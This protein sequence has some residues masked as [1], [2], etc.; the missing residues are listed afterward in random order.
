MKCLMGRKRAL[1][2]LMSLT[3]TFCTNAHSATRPFSKGETI[4][5]DIKKFGIHAGEATLVYNG[6][7]EVQGKKALLITFI[8]SG[9]KFFDEEQIYVDAQTFYPILIKRNLN[10][11]GKEETI[12]EFYDPQKGKV[13]IV[14]TAKG[15]TE[16]QTIERGGQ[17][18]NIYGFIYRLRQ[19]GRIQEGK[20]LDLHLP[21]QDLQFQFIERSTFLI[22]DQEFSTDT[23]RSI[24]KK[25]EVVF[26][27]SPNRIPLKIEGALGFGNMSMIFKNRLIGGH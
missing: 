9:F 23:L 3:V 19:L 2:I 15:K 7:V 16:E 25:Y 11:F 6:P 5:Y 14:K 22:S 26:D 17:F 18:D 8:A 12:M 10:I 24:P 20:E 27:N 1:I 13:R 21:T 4:H